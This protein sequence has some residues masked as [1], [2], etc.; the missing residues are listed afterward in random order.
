M[1]LILQDGKVSG[2][3]K[4]GLSILQPSLI[5]V[6]SDKDVLIK[7]PITIDGQI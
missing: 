7:E 5:P 6:V 2:Y 3:C 4:Y 1:D